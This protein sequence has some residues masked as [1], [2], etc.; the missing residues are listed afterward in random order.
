MTVAQPEIHTILKDLSDVSNAGYAIALHVRYTTPTFLFQSYTKDWL[1]YYSKNGFVMSD[2]TVAWG[3][4]NTGHIAWSALA[5]KD[6]A[7]VLAK[8]ATFGMVY[9]LTCALE[10]DESRS[11][12]SF[13]RADRAFTSE[14]TQQL[15]AQT[16][17]LHA[18]T[19]NLD[20]LSPETSAILRTMSVQFT[21][22]R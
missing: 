5:D 6:S 14:E 4:E 22:S 16:E 10:V 8:A 12:S 18:I 19:A 2:P 15:L 1:D 11:I 7:G 9:G 3:F 13:S 17:N 20:S 21:H